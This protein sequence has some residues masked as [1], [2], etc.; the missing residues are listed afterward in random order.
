MA[1]EQIIMEQLKQ[2]MKD[3]NEVA[4]RTLRAIKSAILVEKTAGP[5]K[6]ALTEEEELSLIQKLAKQRK[7]SIEIFTAQN[8]LD[9]TQKEEEEL[10]ILNTFLPK[11]LSVEA[12]TI[13][14][15]AI[16][17][18]LG[19]K[20]AKEMGKVIGMASKRLKGQAEGKLIADV[21]KS[22]LN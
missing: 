18:E 13:S 5:I 17:D 12:L 20:D 22:L 14:I 4:L 3:K 1:L 21:V 10:V 11:Q 8:R 2:A 6:D 9:L 16:I 7:D 15:Q 19:V